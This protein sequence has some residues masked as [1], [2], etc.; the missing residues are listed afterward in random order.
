M[1]EF[2]SDIPKIVVEIY[3]IVILL[4]HFMKGFQKYMSTFLLIQIDLMREKKLLLI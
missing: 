2:V 3:K 4:F 1:S